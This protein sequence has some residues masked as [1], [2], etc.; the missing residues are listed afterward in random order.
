[1]LLRDRLNDDL[2]SAMR[3]KDSLSLS[4]IRGVKAAI[5]DAE[6]RNQRTT[7]DEDG[8]IGVLTREVKQRRDSIV[9]FE[10]AQRPELVEQLNREI[11]ILAKY[12]PEPLS[13]AELHRLIEEALHST[14]ANGP[15]DLGRVMAWLVPHTRGR[16]DGKLVSEAVRRALQHQAG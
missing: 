3:S 13:D 8:I 1:M 7:L 6:T 5:L 2:K 9:E 16:A 11:S 15:Q 4:V 14:G 12:L 10:R